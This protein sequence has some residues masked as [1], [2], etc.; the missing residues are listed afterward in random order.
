MDAYNLV[1]LFLFI[2]YVISRFCKVEKRDKLYCILATIILSIFVGLRDWRSCGVDMFRYYYT[3]ESTSNMSFSEC[4]NIREGSNFLYFLL[5]KF[6]SSLHVSYQFFLFIIS[7]FFI[8]S[9]FYLIKTKSE[10][11]F[12][13]TILFL[14]LGAFTFSFSGLKQIVAMSLII[15]VYIFSECNKMRKCYIFLLLAIFIHPTSIIFIPYLILRRVKFNICVLGALI[16]FLI[17][18][19]I[20]RVQIG[21]ILTLLYHEGEVYGD[22]VSKESLSGLSLML[23]L[24]A[25]HYLMFMPRLNYFNVL[26]TPKVISLLYL[27]IVSIGIQACASYAYTFTRLNLYFMLFIPIVVSQSVQFYSWNSLFQR[28]PIHK[29]IFYIVISFF[30][31]RLYRG[32]INSELLNDYRF[33][34]L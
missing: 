21:Y 5:C 14:G 4:I 24:F 9:N 13:C 11:P 30:M 17:F 32:H 1:L 7:L 33:F 19:F 28:F 6:F 22:Y 29:Y 10:S 16:V 26:A 31:Y 12:L 25:L 2:A 20:F 34:I 8:S 15:W 23:V 3:Y 18:I 27:I